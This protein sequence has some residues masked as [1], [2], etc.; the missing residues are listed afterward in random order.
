MSST[1]SALLNLI[2]QHIDY[3]DYVDAASM[4]AVELKRKGCEY[5]VALTHMSTQNDIRLAECVPELSL[6]L[7]GH[8]RMYEKRKVNM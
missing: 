8:S 7:G 2:L 5:V 1:F 3:T 4:L 6:V